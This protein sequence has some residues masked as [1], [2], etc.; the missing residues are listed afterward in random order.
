[1]ADGFTIHHARTRVGS[2][3]AQPVQA[4]PQV[5]Q[6]LSEGMGKAADTVMGRLEAKPLLCTA[7]KPQP[8]N[9]T[10]RVQSVLISDR[11]CAGTKR[12]CCIDYCTKAA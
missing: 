4:P 1:M 3:S 8:H 12:N 2:P 7:T 9:H 11:N 5:W 10:R 6:L